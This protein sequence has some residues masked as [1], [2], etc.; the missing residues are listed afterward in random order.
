MDD[1]HANSSP[2]DDGD[3]FATSQRPYIPFGSQCRQV[4]NPSGYNP[5]IPFLH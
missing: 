2:G 1:S 5:D 4:G 3:L